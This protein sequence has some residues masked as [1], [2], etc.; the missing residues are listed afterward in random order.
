MMRPKARRPAATAEQA[1]D[2]PPS[3]L[4]T[5]RQAAL[6]FAAL[7]FL[8]FQASWFV[9]FFQ[10][11]R[12]PVPLSASDAGKRGFSEH[13]AYSHVK[14]LTALGPHPVGS[15]A[16]DKAL[17][18]VL[19]KADEV[20]A[21]APWDV[22][23]EIDLFHTK[24]GAM[25]LVGGLFKGKTLVYSNLKHI[26]VRVKPSSVPEAE[27]N[28]VL[29]SSHIDTVITSPGAGDC[30]S[31]IGVMLE[32]LR[33]VSHWAH[34]FKHSV[35]FLLNTGEEEGLDGA[36]GF[37]TQHPWSTTI[38][39]A[40]DLEA[41]GVGGKSILFQGGP[42]KEIVELYAKV[43]KHPSAQ[44]LAQDF[45]L[46]GLVKSATDFQV[47]KEVA[48]LSGLDF[49]FMQ[50][51]AVYHT[52]N[53]KIE[54][55][56]PGSLQHIGDNILALLLEASISEKLPLIGSDKSTFEPSSKMESVFFDILGMF[57]VRYSKTFAK[58]LYVSIIAQSLLLLFMSLSQGGWTAV[59][60]LVLSAQCLVFSWFFS[61]SLSFLTSVGLAYISSST[62]PYLAHPWLAVILFG[63][64]ALFGALVGHHLGFK[65]LK[66]YLFE[67]RKL[68]TESLQQEFKKTDLRLTD[69]Q[70]ASIE[71]DMRLA[72]WDTERWLFKTAFLQW[73]VL[74]ALG[75]WFEVGASYIAMLW[76][77][78]PALA[79]GLIDATFS[80]Q[81]APQELRTLTLLAALPVPLIACA[82]SAVS[83]FNFIVGGLVRF[84][85]NPGMNPDWL[86]NSTVAILTAIIVCLSLM[87]LFP[88]AHRAGG[89]KWILGGTMLLFAIAVSL[90]A[91]EVF[92]PFTEHTGRAVNVVHVVEVGSSNGVLRPT[93]SYVSFSS[94]TPG[95][96]TK[97]WS[98]IK[99]EGFVC[100]RGVAIDMVTHV[101]KYGCTSFTD[102][103][104]EESHLTEYPML[105]LQEEKEMKGERVAIFRLN[106][107]AARR[108]VMAINTTDLK[109]F[110]LDAIK[111]APGEK[112]VLALRQ[113][114]ES[115]DGW[116]IMQF[117]TNQD[118]P[119][120]FELSLTWS[121]L[122]SVSGQNHLRE[123]SYKSML[124]KLRT[125]VNKTTSKL[126]RTLEKLPSWVSLF[127]KSTSPY[128]LSYLITF[129]AGE[130]V[131]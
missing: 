128:P 39:T 81:R 32:L 7:L 11:L 103:D 64:P 129:P 29:I 58:Q 69:L 95:K 41:I 30:N 115:V 8:I 12:L 20:Q 56:T 83:F 13:R 17:E 1:A 108:W 51:A 125:D 43:A 96:L 21:E 97:E 50:N 105:E 5:S 111:G 27:K 93:S 48:N 10:Y 52:K 70:Q 101:I 34:G 19:S 92:P 76:V 31:N 66:S 45:F 110:Q 130:K 59:K 112:E 55:L 107:Q 88:F 54:L 60:A 82:G 85:R 99:E 75:T 123:T 67:A 131:L 37:I 65:I 42:D 91:L 16:L 89:L 15:Q 22:D 100:E 24:P 4:R 33:A 44:V 18:Y 23:V 47:Y 102:L 40:V 61:L 14:F 78:S 124:L 2:L 94:L 63:M 38:R 87:F 98:F 49:A 25:S 26:V 114:P 126:K 46:S 106:A 53:D 79:Y 86:G 62:I 36:H 84:D 35:I 117:V 121:G 74:L 119:S 28:S 6:L 71:R 77:V 122:T 109:S 113:A 90:V 3:P 127:G 80:P 57:I 68:R 72:A 73:I 104:R 116:H 9:Y 120:N 118:G